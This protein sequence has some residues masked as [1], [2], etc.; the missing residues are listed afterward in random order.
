MET[1]LQNQL[2]FNIIFYRHLDRC[3]EIANSMH[4]AGGSMTKGTYNYKEAVDHLES[5]IWRYIDDE[6]LEKVPANEYESD[7]FTLLRN[8]K[9][10]LR[11]LM[12]YAFKKQIVR[13]MPAD[14]YNE[15]D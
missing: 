2:V 9:E 4:E 14:D 3:G 5:L 7:I 15:S 8:T 6:Y 13:E 1:R 12:L 10:K 11:W